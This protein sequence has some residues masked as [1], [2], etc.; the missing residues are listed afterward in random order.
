VDGGGAAAPSP[1]AGRVGADKE[2]EKEKKKK[3]R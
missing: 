3:K 2:I 1:P